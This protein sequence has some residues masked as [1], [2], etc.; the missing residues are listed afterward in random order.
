MGSR[1][2]LA[3]SRAIAAGM[4]ALAL[5]LVVSGCGARNAL[6][7][8]VAGTDAGSVPARDAAAPS[9]DGGIR[10]SD[11][12]ARPDAGP[13][14]DAGP[15]DPGSCEP[16][17]D[18][19][20]ID[21]V[22]ASSATL[23]AYGHHEG[24][25]IMDATREPASNGIRLRADLCPDADR[26]C[27]CDIVV[28]NTGPI[29]VARLPFPRASLTIDVDRAHVVVRKSPTC[30]CDACGCDMFL[31]FAAAHEDPDTA[32][33]LP[34][35][36]SF[37]RGS[38]ACPTASVCARTDTFRLRV[39]TVGFDVELD[40]GTEQTL[41]PVVVKNVADAV[42]FDTCAACAACGAVRGSFLAWIDAP[43]A[44]P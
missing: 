20:E 6:T 2:N 26:D 9:R 32:R 15:S 44:G 12:S 19:V 43:R 25:V 7:I 29:D 24:V 31:A 40:E 5:A 16:T 4:L 18:G 21:L 14:P 22:P 27:R 39:R 33:D 38:V 17:R 35:E 41:G 23:C 3:R 10:L 1:H 11:A 8:D 36:I 37:A 34:P 42:G 30:R 13:G 28:A